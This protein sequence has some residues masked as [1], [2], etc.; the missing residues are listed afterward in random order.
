[1]SKLDAFLFEKADVYL[2]REKAFRQAEQRFWSRLG[3]D[4]HSMVAEALGKD[5]HDT[6]D[7]DKFG[8]Q[9]NG[10]AWHADWELDMKDAAGKLEGWERMPSFWFPESIE[11]G[12]IFA[13]MDLK[14]S[15][16]VSAIVW[17]T[18]LSRYTNDLA[19]TR[20]VWEKSVTAQL[21]SR[22]REWAAYGDKV[23]SPTG[24][25]G[26]RIG[27]KLDHKEIA[28]CMESGDLRPAL[29]P[30]KNAIEDFAS[31]CPAIHDIVR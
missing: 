15:P 9:E 8:T 6:F 31:V 4:I 17:A 11:D 21:R 30:L 25:W 22:R 3:H 27:I 29:G 23:A 24:E 26:T 5:Y 18:P 2:R 16:A 20:S 28:A 19:W 13:L 1:M 10:W 12:N 14:E 7:S